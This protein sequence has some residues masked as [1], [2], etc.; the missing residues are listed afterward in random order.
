[1]RLKPGD[2]LDIDR[3][4]ED[5]DTI[6]GLDYFDQVFYTVVIEEDKT[7]VVVTTTATRRADAGARQQDSDHRQPATAAR[8]GGAGLQ[9]W[10]EV[11][12][13][14]RGRDLSVAGEIA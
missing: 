7:G 4:E 5:I 14:H 9:S 10:S 3:L 6:Y 11:E 8:V 12:M 13:F 1:M 2:R